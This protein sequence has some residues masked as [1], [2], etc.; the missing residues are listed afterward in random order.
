MSNLKFKNIMSCKLQLLGRSGLWSLYLA[1]PKMVI[2]LAN[3]QLRICAV[4][5]GAVMPE[6]RWGV[7]VPRWRSWVTCSR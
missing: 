6:V 5:Q 4:R 2:E 3:L 1:W 7:S